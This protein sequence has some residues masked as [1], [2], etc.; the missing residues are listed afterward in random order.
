LLILP[1]L[2]CSKKVIIERGSGFCPGVL[3][4]IELAEMYLSESDELYALG[5]LVHNE[6]EISRLKYLGLQVINRENFKKLKNARVLLRAHGEPPE[7]YTIARENNIELIDATCRIVKNLQQQVKKQYGQILD[8]NGQLVVYG[9]RGHPEVIGL[10]G[11]IEGNAIVVENEKDTERIDFAHP[12]RLF[13]QTTMDPNGYEVIIERCSKKAMEKGTDFDYQPSVCGW[14]SRRVDGLT[15]FAGRMD[16]VVFVAG[17]ESSNGKFLFDKVKEVNKYAQKVSGIEEMKAEWFKQNERIGISGATSTP[18][19]LL[20][21][22]A[23][24]IREMTGWI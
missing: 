9:K 21:E 23:Q 16:L 19:W 22:V 12:V 20:Q 5:D 14:M 13:S 7:I 6:T 15:D 11:N 1:A 17:K 8:R 24:K 18:L 2:M 10:D 4:A 3:N